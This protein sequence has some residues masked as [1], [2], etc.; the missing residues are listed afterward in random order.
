MCRMFG[1]RSAVPSQAHRSLVQAENALSDQSLHHPDGWGIGWILDDDAYVIKSANA[2]HACD[3]FQRASQRLTSHT[4][5]AHVRR[6]TVGTVEHVNAHPFRC[7]R[8]LFAHN[9][10]IFG[11]DRIRGWLEDRI[12]P[13]LRPLIHGDTDS[14][15]LFFFVLSRLGQAGIDPTGRSPSGASMVAQI[16]RGALL[17][18]DAL[19][20]SLGMDRPILNVLLTDGRLLV[21]HRAGMPLL[22]STQ[23]RCCADLHTCTEPSKVCMEPARSDAP[24]N[25][26]SI[27]SERIGEEENRWENIADGATV[28][29]DNHFR[30]TVEPPMAGWEAPVLP[31]GAPRIG[32]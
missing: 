27:A 22:L 30:I 1:F 9:G 31:P 7:G 8:W 13:G 11:F 21:A 28:L 5:L 19:A 4:F 24:V 2:A 17:E 26:L 29:L 10:T 20:V 6:A 18:L 14:E 16:V 23:K 25:H 12:E 3:R 32:G 15:R